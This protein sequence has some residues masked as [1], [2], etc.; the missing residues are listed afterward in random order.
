MKLR[1]I[2]QVVPKG[3]MLNVIVGEKE[4]HMF[5]SLQIPIHSPKNGV[6]SWD[7]TISIS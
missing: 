2:A 1:D 3:R 5:N 6:I 7:V 4:V